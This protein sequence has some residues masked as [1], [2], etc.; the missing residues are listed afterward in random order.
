[1]LVLTCQQNSKFVLHRFAGEERIF[2]NG[3]VW[4]HIRQFGQ[5]SWWWPIR[6]AVYAGQSKDW[7]RYGFY[8]VRGVSFELYAQRTAPTTK[9][10]W[11]CLDLQFGKKNQR[12]CQSQCFLVRSSVATIGL[13]VPFLLVQISIYIYWSSCLNNWFLLK[14]TIRPGTSR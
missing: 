9:F 2:T 5:F 10:L 8:S 4:F 1:M 3:I 12:N 11:W 13:F 7:W 14:T 6:P